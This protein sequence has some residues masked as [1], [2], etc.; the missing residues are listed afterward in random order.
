MF[1]GV[2]E[3]QVG[4]AVGVLG[5]VVRLTAELIEVG[6]LDRSFPRI[7]SVSSVDRGVTWEQPGIHARGTQDG[8]GRSVRPVPHDR[9]VGP[10]H[11]IQSLTAS[12]NHRLEMGEAHG[13]LSVEPFEPRIHLFHLRLPHCRQAF[14]HLSRQTVKSI[15]DADQTLGQIVVRHRH[16]ICGAWIVPVDGAAF[17]QRPTNAME[18]LPCRRP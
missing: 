8:N 5:N 18:K 9:T 12:P 15:L 16:L 4:T 2:Y 10:P 11:R 3:T 1:S 6:C 14:V 7:G 17:T 13:Q